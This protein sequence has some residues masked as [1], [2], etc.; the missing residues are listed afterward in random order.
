[1]FLVV[2]GKSTEKEIYIFSMFP[3][4]VLKLCVKTIHTFYFLPLFLRMKQPNL[5]F[6]L[7]YHFYIYLHVYTFFGP[8]PLSFTPLPHFWVGSTLLFSDLFE[9][10]T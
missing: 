5:K 10:K 1:M 7:F 2:F 4:S 3:Y 8:P 9:E 6:F